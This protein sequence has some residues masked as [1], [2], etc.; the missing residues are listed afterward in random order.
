VKGDAAVP[1]TPSVEDVVP[2]LITC[3]EW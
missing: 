2:V 1:E 3:M